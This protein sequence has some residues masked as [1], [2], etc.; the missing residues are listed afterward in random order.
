MN[1]PK[2][3]AKNKGKSEQCGACGILF[4][5]WLIAQHKRDEK[6]IR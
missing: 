5:K 6:K 3:G 4:I 1:C 2:C